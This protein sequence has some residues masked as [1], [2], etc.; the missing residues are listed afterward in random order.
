MYSFTAEVLGTLSDDAI[1]VGIVVSIAFPPKELISTLPEKEASTATIDLSKETSETNS[2]FDP[3]TNSPTRAKDA[4]YTRKFPLTERSVVTS[5]ALPSPS[6]C[7]IF[8]LK[9]TSPISTG[10]PLS[11]PIFS[12]EASTATID[13]SKDTSETNSTFD[14]GTNAPTRAKDASYTRKFPLT[15]RSVVT[16]NALPSP[17]VC[18]IFPLKDTSPI[19]TG[20]P[21]SPPI[22]S[23]EA[24]TATIDLSK[25]TSETKCKVPSPFCGCVLKAPIFHPYPNAPLF[26]ASLGKM[27]SS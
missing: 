14:P 9:D 13:L 19:S 10:V 17:S 16:S 11:P 12:K 3:E 8:P 21:L 26:D 5:N 1:P 22:F 27:V 7:P 18:P 2:T 15:E 25:D 6:V 23:K 20:V 24:S 4:S